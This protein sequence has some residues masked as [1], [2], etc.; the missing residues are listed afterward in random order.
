MTRIGCTVQTHWQRRKEIKEETKK[1]SMRKLTSHKASIKKKSKKHS[2]TKMNWTSW[3][4]LTGDKQVENRRWISLLISLKKRLKIHTG[5][6]WYMVFYFKI[7]ALFIQKNIFKFCDI[8]WF[9]GTK[10]QRRINQYEVS[11][12]KNN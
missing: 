2:F 1:Y 7:E 11:D 9:N 6:Q 12:G 5:V 4:F 10:S 8:L 3:K